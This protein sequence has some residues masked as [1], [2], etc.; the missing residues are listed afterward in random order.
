MAPPPP[1]RVVGPGDVR[2]RRESLRTSDLHEYPGPDPPV[3]KD[4]W[5]GAPGS[6]FVP[7]ETRCLEG[8]GILRTPTKGLPRSHPDPRL[9]RVLYD[10]PTQVTPLSRDPQTWV[11]GGGQVSVVRGKRRDSPSFGVRPHLQNHT[12]V[13]TTPEPS[14]RLGP[15]QGW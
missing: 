2:G 10:G 12:G 14:R 4:V 6:L 7:D 3:G 1:V 5:E 9:S 8:E 13:R 11:V 15:G